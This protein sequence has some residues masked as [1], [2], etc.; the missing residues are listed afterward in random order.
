M[1]GKL[2]TNENKIKWIKHRSEQLTERS[3]WRTP[4]L[5]F[6][7]TSLKVRKHQHGTSRVHPKEL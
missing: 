1:Q 3:V 2:F 5:F 4:Y 6:Q 7:I